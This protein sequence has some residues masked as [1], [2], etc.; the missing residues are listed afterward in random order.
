L[1]AYVYVDTLFVNAAMLKAG[2][3]VTETE[4]PNVRYATYF[5]Q[6]QQQARKAKKG[7]WAKRKI[8]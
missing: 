7:M 5:N 3:V 1:L 2:L 8:R 4:P 6:L